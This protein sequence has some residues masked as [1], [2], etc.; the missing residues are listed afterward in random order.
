MGK[1]N[2]VTN[3]KVTIARCRLFPTIQLV[4]QLWNLTAVEGRFLNASTL[5]LAIVVE[6]TE[7]I[8]TQDDN[9]NQV[10]S[11][12]ECHEEIDQ[13]PYQVKARN[14]SEQHHNKI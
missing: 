13:I 6:Q 7:S 11:G 5:L 14:G 10:A 1:N 3:N 2:K 12:E 9:G 4:R 8:S